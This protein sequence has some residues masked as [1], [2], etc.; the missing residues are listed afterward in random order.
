MSEV[1]YIPC[2]KCSGSGFDGYGTGYDSVCSNCTGGYVGIKNGK[3]D[4]N[5]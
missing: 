3:D 5:E 2:E 4:E 1:E